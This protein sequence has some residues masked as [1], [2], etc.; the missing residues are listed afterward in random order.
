VKHEALKLLRAGRSGVD[1]DR[2]AGR[3]ADADGWCAAQLHS[4]R[5]FT[6]TVGVPLMLRDRSRHGQRR[7]SDR[8]RDRRYGRR[9]GHGVEANALGAAGAA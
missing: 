2:H 5:L 7:I 8:D 6:L 3:V 4:R 9:C 1:V